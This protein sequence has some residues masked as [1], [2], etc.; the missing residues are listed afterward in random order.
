MIK[1]SGK[2]QL[3]AGII[4]NGPDA[5]RINVWLTSVGK[6]Q[7]PAVV[8][9]ENKEVMSCIVEEGSYK[10]WLKSCAKLQ[11]EVCNSYEYY[12]LI[13]ILMYFYTH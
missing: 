4:A 9:T 10:Y 13:F 3:N 2:L 12:S 8:L 11:K 7:L 1:I 5:S 6:E